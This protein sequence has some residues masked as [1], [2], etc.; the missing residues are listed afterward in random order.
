MSRCTPNFSAT[1][2]TRI[3]SDD[4]Q[5]CV[6]TLFHLAELP[7]HSATSCA[8]AQVGGARCRVSTEHVS[9]ITRTR[10]GDHPNRK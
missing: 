5:D 6:I 7:E 2:V 4:G 8:K 1:S 10:V 3:P 9:G